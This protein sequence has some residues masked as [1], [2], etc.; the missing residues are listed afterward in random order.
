MEVPENIKVELRVLSFFNVGMQYYLQ[1]RHAIFCYSFPVNGNLAHHA[2]EMILHSGLAT[3]NTYEELKRKYSKHNLIPMWQEFKTFFPGIN[4]GKYDKLIAKYNQ[5][6]EVRYPSDRKSDVVM[7]SDIRK[8]AVSKMSYPSDRKYKEYRIN[9]EELD[10]F[11]KEIITVIG[12]NPDH[13]KTSLVMGDSKAT[14]ERD[15]HHMLY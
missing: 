14:Y 2:I 9:L 8:D 7:F 13:V 1:T 10:E 4:L 5:W 11:F 15:N 3:K 12:I 6:E